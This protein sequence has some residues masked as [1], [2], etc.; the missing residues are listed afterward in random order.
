MK[1][2]PRESV[3]VLATG[4]V[5]LFGSSLLMVGPK[6]EEW[7]E[8]GTKQDQVTQRIE[9]DK[10][11]IAQRKNWAGQLEKL[12]KLL[13]RHPIGKKVD[14]HWLSVMDRL[15]AKHGV[16]ISK[17]KT[18]A[19]RQEGDV[20]ELPIEVGLDGWEASLESTVH[21][22]FELQSE[23]AMFDIRQLLIKPRGKGA[24]KGRFSLY[25]A[26]T[27]GSAGKKDVKK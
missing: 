4:V 18:G 14:V 16:K 5:V 2:S 13:P 6:I 17:R 22:L 26:Y 7:K 12:S 15:A 11:L 10:K 24:L 19:E 27:R 23:G 8:L 20:Y 21:F 3:L 9:Q 1:V 25:C